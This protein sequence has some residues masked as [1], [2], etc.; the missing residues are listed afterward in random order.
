VVEGTLDASPSLAHELTLNVRALGEPEV[1]AAIV[2]R[3]LER[4][5]G[6]WKEQAMRCF[7]PAAPRPERRVRREEIALRN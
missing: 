4:L 1:M 7:R 5:D 6:C 3:E 2:E